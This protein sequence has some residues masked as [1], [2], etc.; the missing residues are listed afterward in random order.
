MPKALVIDDKRSMVEMLSHALVQESFEVVPAYSLKEGIKSLTQEIDVA[1]VDLRLPDGEGIEFVKMAKVS[2]PFLP[3]IIITAYGTIEKAVTCIKEGA[4]DFITKPFDVDQLINLIKRALKEAELKQKKLQGW[5]KDPRCLELPTLV[6]ESEAWKR[7]LRDVRTLAGLRTTVLL[8]GESGTGKE[9]VARAIYSMGTR[10]GFPFVPINCAAIPKELLEME[11]FG[12]E[13]GAFTGAHETKPGKFELA[14][15]GTIFLDEIGDLDISAQAKLLR[16]LE[17]GEFERVGGIRPIKVDVRI[18]AASN[19]DLEEEVKK[20]HFR[21]D[22]FFR[23]NVFPIFIP[24]L[25]ERKEDIIPLA[26]Y[27]IQYYA[28]EF[29]KPIPQMSREFK[30]ALLSREWKGNVRELK[31]TIERVMI[32]FKEGTLSLQHLS[33]TEKTEADS[34][35]KPLHSVTKEVAKFLEKE[36]ILEALQSARWNRRKAAKLLGISYRTLLTKIKTYGLIP[37]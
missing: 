23:L 30:S 26:E 36:K 32:L 33:T 17:Y 2:H 7:V 27:F 10:A 19:K 34:E 14:N 5:H 31:N 15:N 25:R 37:S 4:Y 28:R 29:N 12:H 21:E 20:G 16:A 3:M 9:L 24:P 6:G 22:L 18:I 1:I 35:C 13:K 8:R 11:L